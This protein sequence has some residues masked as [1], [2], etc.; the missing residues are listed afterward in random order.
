MA[1]CF[2]KNFSY[3]VQFAIVRNRVCLI[4][5]GCLQPDHDIATLGCSQPNEDPETK[6]EICNY[7]SVVPFPLCTQQIKK[8]PSKVECENVHEEEVN[9]HSE[10]KGEENSANYP[11]INA[12]VYKWQLCRC[13]KPLPGIQPNIAYVANTLV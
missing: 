9:I 4:S 5:L 7:D 12:V 3:S 10:A 13:A 1:N 11:K 2:W 8:L 6:L